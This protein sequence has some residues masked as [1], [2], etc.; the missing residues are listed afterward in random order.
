MLLLSIVAN[1]W[2]GLARASI[3]GSGVLFAFTSPELI[4]QMQSRNMGLADT[5]GIEVGKRQSILDR[6]H[7]SR[8][9]LRGLWL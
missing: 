2:L 7:H 5:T 8:H 9:T 1:C 3:K 4:Q 6:N